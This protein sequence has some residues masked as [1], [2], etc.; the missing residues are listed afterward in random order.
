MSAVAKD[1]TLAINEQQLAAR[2]AIYQAFSLL[3][4]S[5]S[6]IDIG[7]DFYS[8]AAAMLTAGSGALPFDLD[9][10]LLSE[11]LSSLSGAEKNNITADYAKY[12][13]IGSDG[14]MFHLREEVATAVASNK[15]KEELIRF[16][17]FFGYELQEQFQWQSDHLSMQLEFV[18]FLIEAQWSSENSERESSFLLGQRDFVQRHIANWLSNTANAVHNALPDHIYGDILVCCSHFIEQ[19]LQWLINTTAALEEN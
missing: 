8:N 4:S 9:V 5:P 3:M 12:F 16:Y 2:A 7:E 15:P 14:K 10:T 11:R 19:D 17:E 13:E 18:R 1:S 6:L